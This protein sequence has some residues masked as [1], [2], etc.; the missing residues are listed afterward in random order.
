MLPSGPVLLLLLACRVSP[1]DIVRT[2][3]LPD[4]EL[5]APSPPPAE[6]PGQEALYQLLFAG[7]LG[8]EAHA[9]G[10]RVRILAWIDAMDLSVSQMRGLLLLCERVRAAL[11]EQQRL[12]AEV[13]AREIALYGPIYA[14]LAEDLAHPGSATEEEL[15]AY[16]TRLA[17][18]R[19]EV[20]AGGDP[21]AEALDRA[22]AIVGMARPWVANLTEQQRSR[23]GQA[24]F[25]LARRLGPLLNPGDY[26][27]FT[28]ISW[29]GGDF[30]AVEST[31]RPPEEGQLDLGGLWSVERLRAP[32]G[33]YLDALQLQAIVVMAV[34]EEELPGALTT[35]LGQ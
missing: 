14:E 34:Q 19:A 12:G 11:A 18:A 30:S 27:E 29:D 20:L 16:A 4:I 15:G 9:A 2:R 23:L 24:R 32:P 6:T 13:A 21:R 33:A 3:N 1:D 17:A 7:E 5:P 8:D 10:Q 28:G 35:R 22:R 25:F 26:G 31:A